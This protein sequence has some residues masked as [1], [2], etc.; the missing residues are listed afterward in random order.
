MVIIK[1]NNYRI[2]N[3]DWNINT[4]NTETILTYYHGGI[5]HTNFPYCIAYMYVPE[6]RHIYY[7][8]YML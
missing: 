1:Y 6:G 5:F 7:V 4:D 8:G 3:C 2:Q